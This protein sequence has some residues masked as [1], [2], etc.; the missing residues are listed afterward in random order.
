MNFYQSEQHLYPNTIILR[1]R[2]RSKKN[3]LKQK[4]LSPNKSKHS[5]LKIIAMI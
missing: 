4:L 3:Y 5:I 1:Q 2:L